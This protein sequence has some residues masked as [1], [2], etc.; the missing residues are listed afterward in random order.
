MTLTPNTEAARA[1]LEFAFA[2]FDGT[3]LI[4]IAHS[5][6]D[7]GA[8]TRASLFPNTPE[9]RAEA[10][11]HA[12]RVNMVPGQ[13]TYFAPSLR[14]DTANRHKRAKKIDVLGSPIVWADFDEPGSPAAGRELYNAK[15]FAP[16]R[17][18]VTGKVPEMRAQAFWLLDEIVKDQVELDEMLAGL[19]V[20]LEFV[21]DPKV[22]NA[23]RVMRL[24]GCIAWPK[25]GKEGR[26]PE[27]TELH[28]PKQAPT[29]ARSISA[30]VATFPR[31]A[32]V[33]A[34][35]GHDVDPGA[36][37]LLTR[38][39]APATQPTGEPGLQAAQPQGIAAGYSASTWLTPAPTIPST[40]STPSAGHGNGVERD[41]LGRVI[42]G[43]D[44]YAMG[45]LFNSIRSLA[46]SLDRWPTPDEL[47]ADAWQ[48][49]STH[50]APKAQRTGET[51]E[52]GL[53][54]E[55]R[56]VTWFKEKVLTH[57]RRALDGAIGGLENVAKCKEAQAIKDAERRTPAEGTGTGNPLAP[58]NTA[59]FAL[60]SRNPLR[61]DAGSYTARRFI[62]RAVPPVQWLVEDF[63]PQ[64]RPAVLA[65]IGG[66]GKSF[67][68]LDLCVK[69]AAGPIF[70]VRP[71][72]FGHDVAAE[73]SALFITAEDD[74]NAVHRRLDAIT[75][76]AALHKAADRLHVIPLPDNGGALH[77]VA[78]SKAGPTLTEHMIHLIEDARKIS[79]LKLVVI[80]PL[81]AFCS[82][83]V[84]TDPA[85]AQTLWSA[86]SQLTAE[87]GASVL[88]LHHMRKDGL[89][90]VKSLA[91]AR[92]SI[93]GTSAIVDGA[94]LA[95]AMYPLDTEKAQAASK[96]LDVPFEFGNFVAGGVVKANDEGDK[97]EH[98]LVR[99]ESGVLSDRTGDVML[100]YQQARQIPHEVIGAIFDEISLA[101][102]AGNPYGVAANAK[103]PLWRLVAEKGDV[104]ESAAK[105]WVK[106]WDQNG[107]FER[108]R[109][110]GS[111]RTGIRVFSRPV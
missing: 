87:T 44:Q 22:V 79:D 111:G 26:V 74:E 58:G 99:S 110:A 82:A 19:H 7:G 30:F 31:K 93:R 50:A 43:R 1:F 14:L 38:T 56:G 45:I 41:M 103:R 69:I 55:G 5:G 39:P 49:Y 9:G 91:Q 78:N 90:E 20:G 23:D 37:D 32:P 101:E 61:F 96:G 65:A 75:D 94:R 57:H 86:L 11:Q 27:L 63:F 48:T 80:D 40:S 60:T 16:H 29:E 73:G 105:G 42:D 10:A 89:G 70:G 92:E 107:C 71:K 17:V 88:I 24:P 104:P 36:D 8:I 108:T 18:V 13:N 83:D 109:E 6:S 95:L 72:W 62:G 12:G 15:G 85:V 54:R 53:E 51:I 4:E 28:T 102:Q 46:A 64:G 97:S 106:S 67:I 100:A 3:G 25:P 2:P 66:L 21:A 77:L 76:D 84:N 35:K 47:F 81:Q 33:P 59:G 98:F 68:T 52:A 34:R